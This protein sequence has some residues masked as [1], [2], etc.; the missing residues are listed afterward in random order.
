MRSTQGRTWVWSR[1]EEL[2]RAVTAVVL[3]VAPP[4]LGDALVVVAPQLVGLAAHP[5]V[6]AT[7][8]V[9]LVGAVE[10]AITNL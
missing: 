3:R 9:R 7:L 5:A 4:D 6:P 1:T 2:V 10:H 8:F